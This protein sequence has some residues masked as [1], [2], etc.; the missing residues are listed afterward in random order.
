MNRYETSYEMQRVLVDWSHILNHNRW[1]V[2]K[3]RRKKTFEHWRA[4]RIWKLTCTLIQSTAWYASQAK[5]ESGTH[6]C[7]ETDVETV[8]EKILLPSRG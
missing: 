6:G 1:S 5:T 8:P 2:R 3:K 4:Q 7:R